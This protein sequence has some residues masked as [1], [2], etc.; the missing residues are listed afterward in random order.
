[1]PALVSAA[2]PIPVGGRGQSAAR[3]PIPAQFMS[4]SVPLSSSAGKAL[5]DWDM[6][7]S[8]STIT[9]PFIVDPEEQAGKPTRASRSMSPEVGRPLPWLE[10]QDDD[11]FP[12]MSPPSTPPAS[13]AKSH[14]TSNLLLPSRH[15]NTTPRRSGRP[16]NRHARTVSVPSLS[17]QPLVQREQQ[18]PSPVSPKF[19]DGHQ[20]KYAGGRFQSAPAPTFLP[21]PTFAI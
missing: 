20:V 14:S 17:T 19:A 18:P 21:M 10:V 11:D 4:R 1:M 5:P 9:D 12:L 13:N 16:V 6:P 7:P 2:M 8:F 3:A 15:S